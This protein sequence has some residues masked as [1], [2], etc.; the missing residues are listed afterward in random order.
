MRSKEVSIIVLFIINLIFILIIGIFFSFVF[1]EE[2]KAAKCLNSPN[3]IYAYKDYYCPE[4][5]N[6]KA[7]IPPQ[8]KAANVTFPTIQNYTSVQDCKKTLGNKLKIPVNQYDLSVDMYYDLI[9][10]KDNCG[11]TEL[12]SVVSIKKLDNGNVKANLNRPMFNTLVGSGASLN[13]SRP[14]T[15]PNNTKIFQGAFG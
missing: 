3:S 9:K 2:R 4:Q 14:N 12:S 7:S 13:L 15:C 11:L 10:Q 6:V 1:I 8:K 5:L